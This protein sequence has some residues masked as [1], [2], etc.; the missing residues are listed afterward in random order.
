MIKTISGNIIDL[1]EDGK[2][3]YIVHGCNCFHTMG[4]GLA[5]QLVRRYPIL[6]EADKTTKR[7][8]REK[9]GTWTSL[10]VLKDGY[11]FTIVNAYTQFFFGGG[12][13][14]FE[15]E[16]FDRFLTDFDSFLK[17]VRFNQKRVAFPKIGAGLAG[18]DWNRILKSIEAFA[19]SQDV[20][21][22]EYVA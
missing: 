12:E 20:T 7:G 3:D 13:D 4:S 15:Y 18:G 9:L 21:I 8:D 6:L 17:T 11:Q 5:G 10:R 16:A 14:L 19:E 22:V 1:A 2:F